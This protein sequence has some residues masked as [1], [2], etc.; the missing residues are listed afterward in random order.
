MFDAGVELLAD[1][2]QSC[3]LC[4][5]A[6]PTEALTEKSVSAETL[7][8][9]AGNGKQ[10]TITC[11]PSGNDGDA[12]V[13][14]LGSINAVVLADMARRGIELQLAGTEHCAECVHAAK[15]PEQIQ[16]NLAARANLCEV[17]FEGKLGAWA[18]LSLPTAAERR[19]VQAEDEK[20]AARRQL[21]RRIVGQ[22]IDVISG[23][24]E[25]PPPPLKAIRA[26]A[27]FNPERKVVLNG[28][29]KVLGDAPVRTARHPAIPAEDWTIAQGCTNCEACARV[30]PTGAM[31]LLE[32]DKAWRLVFLNERCV[33]CDVC[34]EVC[35]PKV[36][37]QRDEQNVFVNTLKARLLR[38]VPRK[39]CTSCD[40]LFSTEGDSPVCPI[41]ITDD[42]DF[43]HI[44]S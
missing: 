19:T 42:E 40:R 10:L 22:S 35:Q 20:G 41:C 16:F 17:E 37:R 44:F 2:C 25:V 39:R 3:A 21:F 26:A 11:A 9:I 33:A 32:D 6:C 8:K 13:P 5:A 1:K 4:V 12:V 23:S 15:G 18:T 34:V 29:Y 28:L 30:C 7:L 43:S 14:C 36:L 27:P 24:D 38:S 31:Q